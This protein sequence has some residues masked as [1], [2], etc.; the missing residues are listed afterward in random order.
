MMRR[1]FA[2]DKLKLRR[3]KCLY[4]FFIMYRVFPLPQS[5]IGDLYIVPAQASCYN[6]SEWICRR[7]G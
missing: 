4:G 7:V 5:I 3:L 1:T 2:G 6:E